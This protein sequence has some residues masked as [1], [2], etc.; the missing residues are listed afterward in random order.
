LDYEPA[1]WNGAAIED[2]EPAVLLARREPIL[3]HGRTSM[4]AMLFENQIKREN[5]ELALQPQKLHELL[6]TEQAD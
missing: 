3:S 4:V 6:D 1:C 2:N 5:D